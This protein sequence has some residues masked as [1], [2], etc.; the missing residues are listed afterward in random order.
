MVRLMF[1][2]FDDYTADL[3]MRWVNHVPSLIIY[4]FYFIFFEFSV[5]VLISFH[6]QDDVLDNN[7]NVLRMFVRIYGASAPTMLVSMPGFLLTLVTKSKDISK[8][9]LLLIFVV[10]FFRLNT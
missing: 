5:L 9:R 6:L 3:T 10:F 4:S 1:A 2:S 7:F 8:P